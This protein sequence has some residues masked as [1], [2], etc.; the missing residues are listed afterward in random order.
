LTLPELR[1]GSN[2]KGTT[3]LQAKVSAYAEMVERLS[4][5]ETGLEI[6]PYR[7]VEIK[8]AKLVKQLK[9]FSHV[10]GHRWS[11]QDC[12]KNALPIERMLQSVP[13]SKENFEYLKN[14]SKLLRDWIPAFSLMTNEE[15]YI[16]PVFVRWLSS[17][18]GLSA[19]NTIEEAVIHSF[20]EIIERWSLLNFLRLERSSSP[21][22]DVNT[23]D[24]DDI[25]SMLAYFESND[26]EVVIKDLTQN[27][28][29]PVY[30][31]ITTNRSLSPNFVGYNTIK[32]GCHFDTKE[33]LKRAF[34]ERMQGTSFQ[35]ER[36]LG[37][38]NPNETDVLMPLYLKGICPFNL[39]EFKVGELTP[40][41]HTTYS[42]T[43][44]A[45]EQMKTITSSLNTDMIVVNHTHPQIKFPVVRV[46]LPAFSDFVGWW[47]PSR[48]S[49]NFI[50]NI[51]PREEEYEKKLFSFL[52]TF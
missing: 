21:N 47:E 2:G 26:I 11:H 40:F 18:N 39:N 49:L 29:F 50:G 25:Y 41:E 9:T 3:K 42:T 17:T 45:F 13:F 10:K 8:D 46:I 44:E 24:D 6:S 19:G 38:V 32:A 37:F 28:M 36:H 23:I 1:A 51:V 31:V 15:V 52:K 43:G 5:L 16:P 7:D 34:T 4:V 22:V 30:A 14:N 35:D 20:C 33:A 27:G 48:V 12:I